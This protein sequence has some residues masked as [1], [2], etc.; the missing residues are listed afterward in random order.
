MGNGV[1][2]CHAVMA[3]SGLRPIAEAL[4]TI[5]QRLRYLAPD[6]HDPHRFHETKSELVPELRRLAQRE[7]AA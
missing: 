2:C 5:A 4:E 7:R 6:H 3:S 1:M